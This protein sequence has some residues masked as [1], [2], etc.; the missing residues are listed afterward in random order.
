MEA[1]S[2][3]KTH[4]VAIEDV[5]TNQVPTYLFS[6]IIDSIKAASFMER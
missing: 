1:Q 2:R 5:K 3:T 6:L 4:M